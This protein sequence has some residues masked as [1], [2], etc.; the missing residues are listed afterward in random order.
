MDIVAITHALMRRELATFAREIAAFP[1]DDLV[2][3][4]LPG[5]TNS[6]GHLAQHVA[7]SLQHFVGALLGGSGYVRQRDTEFS[8]RSRS[9]AELAAELERAASAVTAALHGKSLADFPEVY[10]I[11]LA[12]SRLPTAQFLV[13][14]EAHLAFHLGQ[15]GYL[16]RALTG[17]NAPS[18]ALA[19]KDLATTTGL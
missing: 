12:G 13:H 17:D 2:W 4:T 5:V 16:R 10:P 6:A 7:G 15:A 1:N 8:A 14:L 9:R 18:G 11:E 19:L 3:Q